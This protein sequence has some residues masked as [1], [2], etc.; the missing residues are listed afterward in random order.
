MKRHD[1]LLGFARITLGLGSDDRLELTPFAGRGSNRCYFRLRWGSSCSAILVN[2]DPRRIENTL[3]AGIAQFLHEIGIPVPRIIGHDMQECLLMQEDLGDS[4]LFSMRHEPWESRTRLYRRTL[5]VAHSLHSC[6]E[7][8]LP[9]GRVQLMEPFGPDLYRWER[10]YFLSHFV[11]DLCEIQPGHASAA[12]LEDELSRLAA[13]LSC[14]PRCLVHRDLQ[15]QNVMFR[16]DAPFLIDFQGM[17]FGNRFY[18]LA[19]LLCDP[20]V[21]LLADERRELL[22][23][24]YQHS[25]PASDWNGFEKMFW[26]ASAQRLMQALGAYGYLGRSRGLTGYY[27]YVPQGLRNLTAAAGSVSSLPALLDLCLK[28][29]DAIEQSGFAIISAEP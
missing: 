22:Y 25:E 10:N 14:S 24:Y 23:Y 18:D 17:R 26:E 2:Y 16:E 15:S 20:Y 11:G 13:R 8:R 3:Y 5:A 1:D 6:P 19:S 21:T 27:R 29:Q 28:C 4:D 9:A 7:E 12:K